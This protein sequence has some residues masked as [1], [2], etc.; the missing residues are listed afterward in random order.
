[1]QRVR[2]A[3]DPPGEARDDIEILCAVAARLGQDWRYRDHEQIWDEL[4]RLSPMHAGMSWSRL[5]RL[6]GIQ[7][8]CFSEDML[9]PPY[10]HGR[11]WA[12]E[13]AARGRPAPF[14]VVV[15]DPPVEALSEEYPLRLTTG[16][17][18]DSFNTGVQSGGYRSPNRLGETID[19]S[20]EDAA[21]LGIADGEIVAVRSAR[22]EVRAPVRLDPGL[23]PGLVFMTFHFPDEVDVNQLTIDAT[24]PKSGTAE[25]KAAAVRIDPVTATVGGR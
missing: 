23:R 2:K 16:R 25:F 13:P 19:V 12:E 20:P 7:W 22:G 14:S 18:L 3:L 17:R 4:R 9:E 10:L 21:R 1:V 15:D 6:G 5:D 8:P 11:L 24:D